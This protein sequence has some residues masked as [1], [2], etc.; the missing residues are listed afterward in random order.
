MVGR[1]FM[2]VIQGGEIYGNLPCQGAMVEIGLYNPGSVGTMQLGTNGLGILIDGSSRLT[3]ALR[4][5][6]SILITTPSFSGLV[7]EGP[8]APAGYINGWV[9]NIN[10]TGLTAGDL[11]IW[12][13]PLFNG[14]VSGYYQII[15]DALDNNAV[16]IDIS[17]AVVGGIIAGSGNNAVVQSLPAAVGS[18]IDVSYFSPPSQLAV[19]A[20][21]SN[22]NTAIQLTLTGQG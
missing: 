4:F 2:S 6:E 11:Y 22:T 21:P 16:I 17:L 5:S 8:T 1:D 14:A 12:P 10:A 13:L 19:V 18:A 20:K 3:T 7:V 9:A 15:T